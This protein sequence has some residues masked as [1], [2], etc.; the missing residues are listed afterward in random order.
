MNI[1]DLVCLSSHG[2][3]L[4]YMH[5]RKGKVGVIYKK[6]KKHAL[7][8]DDPANHTYYVHWSGRDQKQTDNFTYERRDL[9]FVSK[10]RRT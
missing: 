8:G 2:E 7:L 1:G 4:V 6:D 5:H 9:K 3:T 10:G